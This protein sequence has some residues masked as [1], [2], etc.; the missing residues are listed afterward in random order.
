M[1]LSPQQLNRFYEAA[2]SSFG[3]LKLSLTFK[4]TSFYDREGTDT[5]LLRLI[6]N[7]ALWI[8]S[9]QLK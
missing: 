6:L 9:Q 4:Y 1:E 8:S 7:V 3:L 2:G 5:I